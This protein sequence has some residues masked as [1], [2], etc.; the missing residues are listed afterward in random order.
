M[1]PCGGD[2]FICPPASAAPVA[3]HSGYFT[4][5]AWEEG[6]KPGTWR[7]F[8]LSIDYSLPGPSVLKTEKLTP[9]CE[10]CPEGTYKSTRGDEL[11][12]CLACPPE[13]A[14]TPDRTSCVCDRPLSGEP[15][16]SDEV[17]VFNLTTSVCEI[18]S[19]ETIV[20][21]GIGWSLNTSV[22]RFEEFVCEVGNYCRDGVQYPC[23]AGRY[24]VRL[25]LFF[26]ECRYGQLERETNP[27]CEGIC[28]AGYYCPVGTSYPFVKP[29]GG[30]V[31]VESYFHDVP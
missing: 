8:S 6:C 28:P 15:L 2:E 24:I 12:Q 14:A 25:Q 20:V 4:T 18:V 26:I 27:L 21:E 19:A 3:V 1:Y 23:P 22:T 7:N 30:F 16:Q 31:A 13:S 29:C 11:Y 17:L 10:L 9:P 5:R